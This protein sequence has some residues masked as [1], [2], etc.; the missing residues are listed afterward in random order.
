MRARI[1]E[2]FGNFARL[3]YRRRLPVLILVL[4]ATGTLVS[5]L[6][7]LE[8]DTSTEGFLHEDDPA[9]LTYNDFREV[10]GRD[11]LIIVT[12]GPTEVFEL[13]FL[14][15]LRSLHDE[16]SEQV[17][18]LD[19]ITSLVNA[20]NTRGDES[21]LI[22]EDLLED[23][24]TNDDQLRAL[25]ERALANPIYRNLLIS[26]DGRF[27]TIVI[28]TVAYS[29]A[30]QDDPLEAGFAGEGDAFDGTIEEEAPFLSDAENSEVV[31]A[32]REILSRHRT[33][34]YN[35]LAAGSPVV[36]D[37]IK[38]A[39]MKDMGRFMV[40]AIG[41]IAL[42]LFLLF[43]RISGVL[44]PL[45]VVVLSLVCTLAIMAIYDIPFKLATQILP[46]FLLAVGV[47]ASVHIL[48]I[49]YRH[50][51]AG[52]DKEDAIVEA[53]SH[54]GLAVLMASLTTAAG[55]ASFSVAEVAPIAE[56]GIFS[57][58]GVMIAFV[59]TLVLLPVL[60]AF[61]PIATRSR[62]AA[63]RPDSWIDRLLG[64]IA[65]F[66]TH[67]AKSIVAGSVVLICLAVLAALQ[68][69]FSHNPLLW[70]PEASEVRRATELVDREM[71]GSVTVDVLLDTGQP[72]GLYDPAFL[73]TLDA[74][75]TSVE[76]A[77][78][79][80]IHVG[81][82]LSIVDILKEIHQALNE[83]DPAFHAIPDDRR[84]VAQELLLFENAGSDDLE[85]VTDSQFQTAR[86]TL[87][88]TWVDSL[89][90]RGFLEDLEARYR[91]A[92]GDDIV[93]TTTGLLP[94]LART[95]HAT[96]RSAARS[97]VIAGIV[98]TIMMVLLVGDLRLG[99]VSMIPNVLPILLVTAIMWVANLPLDMFTMM[100]G[101][102]AIGLAVDDTMHFMHNFLRYYDETGDVQ[103][104]VHHTLHTTGRAMLVTTVVLSIGFFIFMLASMNNIFNFGL[105][106][107]LAIS[108]AL[109]ADYFLAPALMTLLVRNR[110]DRAEE[111]G[112][113]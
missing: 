69:R 109:L 36:T 54:S 14:Q 68:L 12:L 39:M 47:G 49:F 46:S 51:Q 105:L 78:F 104:A 11:E 37:A 26:E 52:Q 81:K 2:L 101:S 72:N 15:R 13:G 28:R 70:L 62:A 38:R 74:T 35:L 45:L 94:L 42:F 66:S 61:L 112:S 23:F 93:I 98:I 89:H 83:N 103:E 60:V 6:P 111:E 8:I 41:T 21:G 29:T 73:A 10:F 27:T 57:A 107:G 65:S 43:H 48:V 79:D 92:F 50:L 40:M 80:P 86:V 90:Y 100:I 85:D 9:L 91:T 96:M 58:V 106:T 95:I 3:L 102:I 76:Q 56:L 34:D 31:S 5:Q 18:H 7:R 4:A 108:I 67:H 97:Y 44:M 71:D 99:L 64:A 24:P 55:L 75:N 53:M 63:V 30:G 1:E 19:D 20:R 59:F 77:V 87:K 88:V 22:V 84:L 17:P 32:V 16:L 33:A 82:Q 113:A 25:R 110:G